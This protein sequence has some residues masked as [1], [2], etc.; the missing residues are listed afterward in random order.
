MPDFDDIG[1][2]YRMTDLQA[3]IGLVQLGKLDSFVDERAAKAAWYDE[4]LAELGWLTPPAVPSGYDHGWQA[5]VSVV[6]DDAPRTRD[7]V[8]AAMHE[9]GI[10]G[11]PGTHS[12]P[13]LTAYRERFGTS[14]GD[15]PVATRL[16]EQTLALPLHNAMSED[17]YAYVVD[18]LRDL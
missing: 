4:Q 7:E 2:N 5:Y 17:D 9:R 14:P 18:T 6:A 1:F 3:A 16:A 8:L 12:V 13:S 15:F 11:R 10:G